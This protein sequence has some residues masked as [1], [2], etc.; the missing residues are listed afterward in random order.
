MVFHN[1]V[2][3]CNLTFYLDWTQ[4]RTQH[5]VFL[6]IKIGTHIFDFVNWVWKFNCQIIL[7][8][9][10]I[11]CYTFI[12]YFCYKISWKVENQTFLLCCKSSAHMYFFCKIMPVKRTTLSLLFFSAFWTWMNAKIIWRVP[13]VRLLLSSIMEFQA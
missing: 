13:D 8:V 10:N 2:C 3:S 6:F 11:N 1:A 4:P 7:I 5:T 12:F 9:N